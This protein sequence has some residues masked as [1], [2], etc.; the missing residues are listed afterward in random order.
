MSQSPETTDTG[1]SR[2]PS[3]RG[4]RGQFGREGPLFGHEGPFVAAQRAVLSFQHP[5]IG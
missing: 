3:W 2:S 5:L 1:T 4:H